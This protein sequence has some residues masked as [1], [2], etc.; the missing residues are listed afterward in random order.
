MAASI[1]SVLSFLANLVLAFPVILLFYLLVTPEIAETTAA[2]VYRGWRF[3]LSARSFFLTL[4]YS[5]FKNSRQALLADRADRRD[6]RL[7][8]SRPRL[9]THDPL[10]HLSCRSTRTS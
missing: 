6:R 2:A 5:R 10:R 4:F 1:D 8:L 7:G 9:R 3:F